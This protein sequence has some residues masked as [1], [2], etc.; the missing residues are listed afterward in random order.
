VRL[1]VLPER[2]AV[3]RLGPDEEAPARMP[4]RGLLSITRTPE[5]LSI[6]CDERDAPAGAPSEKGWRCLAVEGPLPF[7][8]TGILASLAGPLAEAR[9]SVFVLSTFDTDYLLVRASQLDDALA[10]LATA[11]HEVAEAVG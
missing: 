1:R 2:F 3:V 9:V 5:E 8:A 10:T 6:V 7:T 11:G 4:A